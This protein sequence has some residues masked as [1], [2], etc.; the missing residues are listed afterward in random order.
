[1]LSNLLQHPIHNRPRAQTRRHRPRMRTPRRQTVN[2]SHSRPVRRR[3][4]K[5]SV[6][7]GPLTTE[8][9]VTG[10][11]TTDSVVTDTL[12]TESVVTDTPTTKATTTPLQ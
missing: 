5:V 1:M 8:S 3:Q 2:V 4:S 10:T 11:L 9:V 7:T 6:V 12:T